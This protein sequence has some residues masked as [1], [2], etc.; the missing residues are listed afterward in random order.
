MTT[1]A[2]PEH[3]FLQPLFIGIGNSRLCWYRAALPAMFMGADWA[4]MV[5]SPPRSITG[6]NLARNGTNMH[7]YDIVVVQQ[8]RGSHWASL[9]NSLRERGIVVLYEIDDYIHGIRRLEHHDFAK[10]FTPKNLK[11]FELCMRLCDGIICSTEYIARRYGKF[12]EH[13]YVCE[14]GLDMARYTYSRVERGKLDDAETVTIGWAGATGHIAAIR[15]WLE[16]V[17]DIMAEYPQVCFASV[18]QKF[19]DALPEK[20]AGRI[21]SLPF[22]PLENYPAAMTLFDIALAPTHE[23]NFSRGKSTLRAMESAALGIPTVAS[24]HYEDVVL[25]GQ[26]GFVVEGKDEIRS[27][28]LTLIDS[29]PLRH[30]FGDASREMALAKFDMRHRVNAWRTAMLHAYERRHG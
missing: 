14:N 20:Y 8:A 22:M 13:V 27:A 6:L 21:M 3:K 5:G 26:T 15:P 7:E 11:Q 2:E 12:N 25:D 28:L 1:A 9:I 19:A 10:A 16:V 4:G 23:T 24:P 18:G 30:D 17:T 29:Q